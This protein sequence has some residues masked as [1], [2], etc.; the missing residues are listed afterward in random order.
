MTKTLKERVDSIIVPKSSEDAEEQYDEN[1]TGVYKPRLMPNEDKARQLSQNQR[2]GN[3]LDQ[4]MRKYH[5]AEMDFTE[6]E[7]FN[8]WMERLS[9]T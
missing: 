4:I 5:Y 9:K 8:F 7:K 2:T 6:E 1:Y 3:Y